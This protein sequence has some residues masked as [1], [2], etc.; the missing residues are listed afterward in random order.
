MIA[1]AAAL[2]AVRRQAVARPCMAATIRSAFSGSPITPV[3][4]TN[5]CPTGTAVRPPTRGASPHRRPPGVAGEGVG[6]A[7]V[8]ED[9]EPA[10]APAARLS[11][12]SFSSHQSTGPARVAERVKTP[13][14]TD[15]R[16]HLGQHHVEPTRIAHPGLGG[17][18]THP[19]DRRQHRGRG[20]R[21]QRRNPQEPYPATASPQLQT[22]ARSRGS[23]PAAVPV[24]GF[25]I[26]GRAAQLPTSPRLQRLLT[27]LALD[28]RPR[29][30]ERRR[31]G[32]ALLVELDEVPAELDLRRRRPT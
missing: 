25:S 8:D 6:V 30:V 14:T 20:R 17:G 4:A 3:D 12:L 28:L 7:R 24:S 22:A 2:A 18:E 19:V 21:R 29:L 27:E 15:T 26:L 1:R 10:L 16:R 9:G 23:P 32:L 31:G 13:A 11:A 5:T